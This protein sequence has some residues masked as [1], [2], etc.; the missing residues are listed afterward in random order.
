YHHPVA[1]DDH[2]C[3][4]TPRY[5][6]SYDDMAARC[7][8]DYV[9]LY[10]PRGSEL[11]RIDGVEPD[12]VFSQSGE[13]RTTYFAGHF[14]MQPGET[15]TVTFVYMLPAEITPQNYRLVLQRQSGAN[16][17]PVDVKV[18]E[19]SFETVVEEGRFGWP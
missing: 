9:R 14:I 7:Y 18:G 17:L 6:T 2:E 1:V 10:A 13:G 12:S 11:V 15:K 16:A 19:T 4:I 5:G 3:D 8:F